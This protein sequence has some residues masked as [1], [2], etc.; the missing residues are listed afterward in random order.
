MTILP[1][2]FPVACWGHFAEGRVGVSSNVKSI[3]VIHL[4]AHWKVLIFRY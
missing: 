3:L 4:L 1:K 2:G